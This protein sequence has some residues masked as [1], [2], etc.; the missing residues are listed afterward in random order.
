MAHDGKIEIS[1]DEFS[2]I[3]LDT[4]GKIQI[5]KNNWI[6]LPEFAKNAKCDF[7]AKGCAYGLILDADIVF[8][9][10]FANT[11]LYKFSENLKVLMNFGIRF[12]FNPSIKTNCIAQKHLKNSQKFRISSIKFNEIDVL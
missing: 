9:I 12:E 6:S 5:L 4:T 2:R 10:V 3:R 7:S 11:T 8:G 1:V